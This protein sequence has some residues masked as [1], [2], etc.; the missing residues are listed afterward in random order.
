LPIY[1]GEG[2]IEVWGAWG[3]LFVLVA[4]MGVMTMDGG[5]NAKDLQNFPG[6]L[7]RK[8]IV[9]HLSGVVLITLLLGLFAVSALGLV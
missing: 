2:F 3:R 9:L 6:S 1:Y 4:I 7:R 5:A 8:L